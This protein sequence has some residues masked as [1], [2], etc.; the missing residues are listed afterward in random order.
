MWI[1]TY[2]YGLV[3]HDVYAERNNGIMGKHTAQ[4][5]H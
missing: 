1:Q 5:R 2:V 3:Y 4:I